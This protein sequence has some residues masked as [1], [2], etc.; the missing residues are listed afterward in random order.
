MPT[1]EERNVCAD[2]IIYNARRE[3]KRILD[4]AQA[5]ALALI[6]KASLDV[7]ETEEKKTIALRQLLAGHNTRLEAQKV[8]LDAGKEANR[9]A[10]ESCVAAQKEMDDGV[11]KAINIINQARAT[12]NE[13]IQAAGVETLFWTPECIR[14]RMESPAEKERLQDIVWVSRF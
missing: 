4:A 5:E 2:E 14:K 1:I 11:Q 7:K 3:A 8:L 13:T 12:A 10:K 6:E 9:I